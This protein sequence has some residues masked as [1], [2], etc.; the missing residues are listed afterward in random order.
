[1]GSSLPLQGG[2]VLAKTVSE[3]HTQSGHNF[4]EGDVLRYDVGQSRWVKAQANNAANAEV[5]GVVSS[6]IS[7][8]SFTI[9]YSGYIQL[10]SS[11][12]GQSFPALFLSDSV[13]GALV[14][15]P[16]SAIGS[17]VKPVVIRSSQASSTGHLVVNYLGTQIGG[18]STVSIDQIQP[19]GTIMPFVG[20]AI[21]DTWLEC[22]GLSFAVFEYTELY[23]KL[24]HLTGDRTPTYGYVSTL[25]ATNLAAAGIAVGDIVQYKNNAATAW[26]GGFYDSNADQI[27]TVISVTATTLVVQTIPLYSS[28]TK[29]FSNPDVAFK[30]GNATGTLTGASQYRILS[31]PTAVRAAASVSITGTSITHFNTPDLRGRFV[32][33]TN[34]SAFSDN[35]REGDPTFNT[36][37]GQY[38]L[39]VFGG[40]EQHVLSVGELPSHDHTTGATDEYSGLTPLPL[41]S[42][43]N[44]VVRRTKT[45][46]PRTASA[47]DSSGSGQQLD[48]ISNAQLVINPTGS[49]TPHN[50]M[51]PYLAVRYIIKSKPYTR[52]AIIDTVDIDFPNLLVTD[53]RP[54]LIRGGGVNDPL[55]FKTNNSL[56]DSGTE[57]MRISS[58]GD[59]GIGTSVLSGSARLVVEQSGGNRAILVQGGTNPHIAA[60]DGS[61]ITKMQTMTGLRGHVGSESNHPFSIITNNIERLTVNNSGFVG[62]GKPNPSTNLDIVGSLALSGKATSAATITT[63]PSSTLTTKGYVDGRGVFMFSNSTE[64]HYSGNLISRGTGRQ[65]VELHPHIPETATYAIITLH[66]VH[67]GNIPYTVWVGPSTTVNSGHRYTFATA[68]GSGDVVTTSTQMVLPIHK[69]SATSRRIYYNVN[70]SPQHA[71]DSLMIDVNGYYI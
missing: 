69:I 2:T 35:A 11:F 4:T 34:S 70:V 33:G 22:S 8:S 37:I 44:K 28:A 16:P 57:R 9:V 23:D 15:S 51:P 50:N 18:S 7:T 52:A 53:L 21:P 46:E 42:E 66:L 31:S 14:S 65:T 29:T 40:E 56:L 39:G 49:N 45:G 30:N 43:Y 62:I 60:S 24:L 71:S 63:D 38:R 55:V 61:V 1:M 17:V 10:P 3:T 54:G 48:V 59:V 12:A 20:N 27:G 58:N 67:I 36:A 26:Q 32:L 68:T 64:V 6:V 5:A 25:T 41:M 13:P 47:A 19:V